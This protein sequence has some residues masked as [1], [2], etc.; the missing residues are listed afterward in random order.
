MFSK[1]DQKKNQPEKSNTRNA[2]TQLTRRPVLYIF[3]LF[4]LVLVLVT[5]VGAPAITST[6]RSGQ[7]V[8]GSYRGR[9]IA[10]SQGNYFA[11]QVQGINEQVRQSEMSEQMDQLARFIWRQA[12]NRTL[13]HEA[14]LYEAQQ[15]GIAV[16]ER[17]ID[18]EIAQ[19]PAYQENGQFSADLYRQASSSEKYEVR[20]FLREQII[21]EKFVR[22]KTEGIDTSNAESDFVQSMASPQRRFRFVNYA[23]SDFPASEVRAFAEANP[24]L[25][26]RI[27][28][29]RI[30]ILE[31]ESRAQQ[32][33]EQ[34]V[35]Q[36]SSFEEMARSHSQDIYADSGGNM[37]WTYAYELRQSYDDP[38]VLSGLYELES[39]EISQIYESRN[40][41]VI[42]RVNEPV[43]QLDLDSEE[44]IQTVRDYMSQFERGIIEDYL[45]NQASEFRSRAQEVGYE[46]ALQE[47]GAPQG[48]ET[49]FFPINFGNLDLF[50]TVSTTGDSN[51]LEGAATRQEFFVE[52]FSLDV[53]GI[54]EPMV[55]GNRTFVFQAAEE[56]QSPESESRFTGNY[57]E[58]TAQQFQSQQLQ[59]SLLQDRFIE[60]NFNAAYSRNVQR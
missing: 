57:F 34:I 44:A 51:P 17:R 26:R 54:S 52:L 60:D 12:F 15:S 43:T 37:D 13:F 38:S 5:F 1:R 10:Y 28:L 50:P 33:R 59:S 46:T 55:I 18:R 32:I 22:D 14:V 27:N 48:G 6:A 4:V 29:S 36:Q 21:H 49:Q 2:T 47:S 16:T 41:W 25:F 7:V 20:E 39:G 19:Y 24:D 53:G 23:L 40:G 45:A 58:F 35:S 3:S 8:F 42:Y 31:S 11:R 56:R 9:P 30:T